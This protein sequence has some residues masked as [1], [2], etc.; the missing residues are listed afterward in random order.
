MAYEDMTYEAIL[1]RM[2]GRVE[3]QYPNLD[4]REGSL[5]FNALAPAA[6]ELAIAYLELDNARNES[7]VDTASR[8]YLYRACK[9]IGIDTEQFEATGGTFKGEFNVE[10]EIG[11]RWNCDLYNYNVTEYI[12]T[13]ASGNYEYK[14]VSETTGTAPNNQTGDLTPITDAPSGLTVAK[15][16]A[17]LIEGENEKTDDQIKDTYYSYVKSNVSDGNVAQYER[18][19]E[20]YTGIGNY[21]ITPL[22][23]GSNTVKVSI[24]SASN[25]AAT[26]TLVSEA[27]NYFDP[28]TVKKFS[29]DGSTKV[30]TVASSNAPAVVDL[31]YVGGVVQAK[32]AYNYG[33]GKLTFSTAP[34]SGTNNI[35]VRYGG[36]M[37]NG[38]APIG[39]FV[40]VDTATE[41]PISMT[42]TLTLKSGYSNTSSIEDALAAYFAEMAY[43][44]S[45]ISYMSVGAIILGVEGVESLSNLK[46]NGSTNDVAL[47]TY[48]IPVVGTTTWTVS[49]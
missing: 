26:S 17:C 29:G 34:A 27:Q 37:G 3:Q 18:W 46:L 24:L 43:K 49:S 1:A 23:N 19:C 7:F 35:E 22:W 41:V 40:T 12:G 32:T 38:V 15:I 45:T 21:K 48:Q 25:R 2:I 6:L 30:F 44:K 4:R 13:N 28:V 47:T 33:G 36:G 11:S 10:V 16:T 39:A 20:G 42:A 8:E 14:L 31:V 5:I 9:Q